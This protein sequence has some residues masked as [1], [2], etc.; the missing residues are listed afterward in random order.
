MPFSWCDASGHNSL[1]P[2]IPTHDLCNVRLKTNIGISTHF[3]AVFIGC[4][5][6]GHKGLTI[7]F[8]GYRVKQKIDS[9]LFYNAFFVV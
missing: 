4:D 6:S 3:H 9:Q 5:V 8:C 7:T 2:D 1:T